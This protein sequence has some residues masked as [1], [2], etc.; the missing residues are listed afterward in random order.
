MIAAWQKARKQPET[1]FLT[2]AHQQALLKEAAPAV[3]KFDDDVKQAAEEK[4]LAAEVRPRAL[5]AI[6]PL[7]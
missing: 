7:W 5:A 6:P 4:R 3:G 2:A 1:G